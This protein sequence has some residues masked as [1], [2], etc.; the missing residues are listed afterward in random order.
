MNTLSFPYARALL[1]LGLSLILATGIPAAQA[2]GAPKTITID[3]LL[4]EMVDRDSMAKRPN[5][6][7]TLKQASSHDI[8][9]RDPG[10]PATWH[11]NQDYEQFL[12]T[13]TNE[14]R[15]EWVI[16]D[17][18]GPG[19]ITRFW[20]PL[21][22]DRDRQMI[23]FYFDGARKPA[24]EVKFNDL[25]SGRAFVPPP[26]A[27]VAWND[28]DL[29]HQ[30]VAAPKETRGVAG[31][32]YLPIPFARHC[33]ITLDQLPFYYIINYR[34]Y[35]PGT[36]VRTF[37]MSDFVAA[38]P[39]VE[40]VGRL[41]T[42]PEQHAGKQQVIRSTLAPGEEKK[43]ELESGARAVHSLQIEIDPKDAAQ[44]L[45]STVMEATFDGEPIAA[46]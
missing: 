25:L 32:L 23:R 22:P 12:R 11:S 45:R 37:T 27:F 1:L 26:F 16:M 42:A 5:P 7:F 41:L 46:A 28:M 30:I 3:S 29:R 17:D 13:E 15:H 43:L 10:D 38:R 31:D 2:A 36:A 21:N 40:R 14:G 24:I 44:A 6:T 35:A 39:T 4:R 33:K 9:K 19:A 34:A 20:L 8:H 18:T